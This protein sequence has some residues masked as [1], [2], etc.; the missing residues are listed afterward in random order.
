MAPV[1]RKTASSGAFKPVHRK[2]TI[3]RS[4]QVCTATS[5]QADALCV[6]QTSQTNTNSFADIARTNG[7]SISQVPFPRRD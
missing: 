6:V 5:L 7:Y 2:V 4:Y 1:T 3:Y